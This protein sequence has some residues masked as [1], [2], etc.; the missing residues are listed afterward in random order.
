MCGSRSRDAIDLGPLAAAEG[1]T[2]VAID[3]ED[4]DGQA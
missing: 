4:R 2:T 1:I 3:S